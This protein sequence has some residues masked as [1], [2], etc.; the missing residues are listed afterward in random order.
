MAEFRVTPTNARGLETLLERLGQLRA[1]LTDAYVDSDRVKHL[2]SDERLADMT[3][4]G[5]GDPA[6]G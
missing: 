3:V 6:L 4:T 5:L 1:T 2:P